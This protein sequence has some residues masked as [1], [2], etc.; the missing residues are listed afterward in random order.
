MSRPRR[1]LSTFANTQFG[2][3]SPNIVGCAV[4]MY[5]EMRRSAAGQQSGDRRRS[6]GG[7]SMA[8]GLLRAIDYKA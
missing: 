1:P 2:Q 4:T 7:R 5:L 3:K 8:Q 6:A